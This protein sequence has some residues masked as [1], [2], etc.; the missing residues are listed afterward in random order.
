MEWEVPSCQR[1]VIR[2]CRACEDGCHSDVGIGITQFDGRNHSG[3]R[4]CKL[5]VKK[6]LKKLMEWTGYHMMQ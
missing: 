4:G 1:R 2:E 3:G 5:G 6:F